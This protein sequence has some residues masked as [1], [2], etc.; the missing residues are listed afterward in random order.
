MTHWTFDLL[1][2]MKSAVRTAM[3]GIVKVGLAVADEGKDPLPLRQRF[4]MIL[5]H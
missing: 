3:A 4:V 1:L 5:D 2:R